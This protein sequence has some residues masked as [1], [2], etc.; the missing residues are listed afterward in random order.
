MGIGAAIVRELA[1]EGAEPYLV[2]RSEAQL[3]SLTQSL[4]E[5]GVSCDYL[6]A[7]LTHATD[8]DR[9]EQWLREKGR[10]DGI[11]HNAGIINYERF[12]DLS[13]SE[14]RYLFAINFFSILDLTQR[15]LPLLEKSKR[16]TLVF[17]SSAAAWR[18][19]PRWSIYCASKA[20]LTS[21]V[22][23]LRVELQPKGIHCVTIYPG[24]TQTNLSRNV[25]SPG[26]QPYATTEGKGSTPQAVARKVVRAYRQGKRDE[27]VIPF[28]FLYRWVAFLWPS[29]LDNK[30][31]R[32]ARRHGW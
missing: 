25:K 8:C 24:V 10:L 31:L 2:A 20:A 9:V 5:Q 14:W 17:M 19:L 18:A 12:S 11:I 26:P 30:F 28:N 6:S 23:A 3:K 16:P 15:L 27:Y 7:D 13:E 32:M 4:Q 29:L 1:R 22:E 21:W